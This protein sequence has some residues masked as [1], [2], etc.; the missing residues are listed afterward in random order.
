MLPRRR[1]VAAPRKTMTTRTDISRS[2]MIPL[3]SMAA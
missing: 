1:R 2:L 3:H